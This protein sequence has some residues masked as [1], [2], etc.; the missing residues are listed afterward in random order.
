MAPDSWDTFGG[1]EIS[2]DPL[3]PQESV[4][5]S[6]ALQKG[7]EPVQAQALLCHEQLYAPSYRKRMLIPHEFRPGACQE[8][9]K[10]VGKVEKVT[11]LKVFLNPMHL[12]VQ[13]AYLED[14][15]CIAGISA[16]MLVQQALI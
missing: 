6:W 8:Y 11:P 1:R 13:Q 5:L 15:V 14:Q 7:F 9:N 10:T 2:S 3:A 12:L 16:V 4:L